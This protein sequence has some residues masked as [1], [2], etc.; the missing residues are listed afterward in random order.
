MR[1]RLDTWQPLAVVSFIF[2]F[3]YPLGVPLLMYMLMRY[4][5][6]PR[7]A[8]KKI[9]DALVTTMIGK[10]L[11]ATTTASSMRMAAFIGVVPAMDVKKVVSSTDEDDE[12]NRRSK[13]VFL[14]IFPDH[15][16]CADDAKAC[17]GHE[18]PS[19]P[20]HF[21]KELG[22]PSDM[23]SLALA[24]RQWFHRADLDG[25]GCLDNEE[26][27]AEFERI[28]LTA[29]E[30]QNVMRLHCNQDSEII[31]VDR[32]VG[33]LLHVLEYAVHALSASDVVNI[34]FL[35]DRYDSNGDGS[36]V[37]L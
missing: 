21:L 11:K 30:A 7:L 19:M 28:G 37:C 15:E 25:S 5:G 27:V 24:A 6:V 33:I 10:Y 35:F 4:N 13:E 16:H 2:V 9:G 31:N 32:F 3:V 8:R 34:A 26:L 12:F 22:Y 20:L 17:V 23:T 18:L 14:E 29:A 36:M 1:C